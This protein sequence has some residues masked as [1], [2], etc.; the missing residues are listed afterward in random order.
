MRG[1]Y[2]R[3]LGLGEGRRKEKSFLKILWPNRGFD[4][5]GEL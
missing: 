2:R 4:F 5:L 3:Q 1:R